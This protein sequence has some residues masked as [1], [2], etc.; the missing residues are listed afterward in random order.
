[1]NLGV[2][3]NS[4]R[5]VFVLGVVMGLLLS[6]FFMLVFPMPKACEVRVAHGNGNV[7]VVSYGVYKEEL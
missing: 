1:M 7:S 4:V 6:C 5:D 3:M 2:A